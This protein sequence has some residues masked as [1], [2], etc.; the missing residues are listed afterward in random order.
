MGNWLPPY[1]NELANYRW[2]TEKMRA[3]NPKSAQ[4]HTAAAWLKCL[5]WKFDE[6]MEHLDQ[7]LR[8]DPKF[9]RAHG[10]LAGV[11]L[12]ARGDPQ[13]ALRE[14]KAAERIDGSD[15]IIQMHLGTPYYF[16]RDYSNAIAQYE[17]ARRVLEPTLVAPL[18][19]LLAIVYEANGQYTNALAEYE[20]NETW[21]VG[22]NLDD[23]AARYRK[24]QAVLAEQGPR[25][26]W[27]TMLNHLELNDPDPY[28]VARLYARL[29]ENREALDLL[30]KAFQ[31][32]NYNM[33]NLLLDDCF[34]G[35]HSEP[36]FQDLVKRMGFKVKP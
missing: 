27:R 23:I 11:M 14:F 25:G 32:H 34:D 28:S 22:A 21:P 1:T 3:L 31:E 17:K 15:S 29:G 10:L 2:V 5:D 8:A 26:L 20:R 24:W 33:V 12:R 9:L 4:Y 7:A 16:M 18:A 19:W 6:E 35:L 36:R 30:E 13:A